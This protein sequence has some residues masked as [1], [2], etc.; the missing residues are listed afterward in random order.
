M[1]KGNLFLLLMTS[2]LVLGGCGTSQEGQGEDKGT[3]QISEKTED[4]KKIKEIALKEGAPTKLHVTE[5][6]ST[7]VLFQL[8]PNKGQT[9]KSAD[10]KVI[11][12]S[13]DPEVLK[14]EKEGPQLVTYLQALKA[15]K[16]T[17]TIQS[18]VQQETK[19]DI[20]MD[21]LDSYFDRMAPDGFFGNSWVNVDFDHESDEENPYIKTIAEEDINHQFYF[22]NSYLNKFYVE[23]EFTFY[24]EKD[25]TAHMPKLGFVFSTNEVND[26]NM[27]AVSFIYFDTDCRNGNTTFKNVGYNEI[28]N[29]V[30]GWDSNAGGLAKHFTLYS[31]EAGVKV[32]QTFKMGVVKEG[33]NYHIYFNGNYVRSVTSTIE[34]FSVD[35]TYE[36]AAPTYCGLFDFKSEVKYS[37]YK[38]VTDA[39]EIAAKIP[40]TPDFYIGE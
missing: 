24:S 15:G 33:F 29:G 4:N 34:G 39:E 13:S 17:L 3:T 20:E 37:N 32:E 38:F 30:W 35:K 10:K 27:P 23:S 9:L 8:V 5:R 11:F 7:N 16:V 18:N 36:E 1:K 6:I 25:G 14:V 2:L 22:R 19:L 31:D 26:M 28:V 12:T 21:V 40:A